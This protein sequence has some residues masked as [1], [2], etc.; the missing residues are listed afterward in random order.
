M[1]RA[2][3]DHLERTV[4]ARRKANDVEARFEF[5][6]CQVRR[7]HGFDRTDEIAASVLLT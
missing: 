4:V 2:A 1:G 7:C 6:A 5:G 3:H